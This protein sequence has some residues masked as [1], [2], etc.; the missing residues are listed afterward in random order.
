MKRKAKEEIEAQTTNECFLEDKQ[1]SGSFSSAPLSS[2]I[3]EGDESRPSRNS[4]DGH[5]RPS[6]L[7][8]LQEGVPTRPSKAARTELGDSLE[9]DKP[10]P[11]IT[12]EV[13]G[14]AEAAQ[15]SK[16]LYPETDVPKRFKRPSSVASTPSNRSNGKSSPRRMKNRHAKGSPDGNTPI[17]TLSHNQR[18]R[19]RSRLISE[20]IQEL[21]EIIQVRRSKILLALQSSTDLLL[22]PSQQIGIKK[23][24]SN[25]QSTL[26]T[27]KALLRD[28]IEKL[29]GSDRCKYKIASTT[30]YYFYE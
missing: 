10:E 4:Y 18:E 29:S 13:N 3:E 8:S 15:A 12:S 30:F 22:S 21:G 7:K 9:G 19:E 2:R 23:C 6:S 14:Q 26:E 5:V 11:V 27:A 17:P 16:L 24:H 20:H 1:L 25:K 28:N